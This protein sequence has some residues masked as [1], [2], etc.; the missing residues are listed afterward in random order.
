MFPVLT[1]MDNAAVNILVPIFH[2]H[3]FLKSM[4]K[5]KCWAIDFYTPLNLLDVVQLFSQSG[6]TNL[7]SHQQCLKFSIP[8]DPCQHLE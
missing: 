7:P 3:E 2:V 1:I 6:S 5:W 8:P 4:E